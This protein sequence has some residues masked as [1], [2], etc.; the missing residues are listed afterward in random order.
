MFFFVN[1]AILN[2]SSVACYAFAAVFRRG[3]KCI[4]KSLVSRPI[5]VGQINY[6][7]WWTTAQTRPVTAARIKVG[8]HINYAGARQLPLSHSTLH[9]RLLCFAK[10]FRFAQK[11]LVHQDEPSRSRRAAPARNEK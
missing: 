1:Y 10:S 8:L 3:M 7:T 9:A 4:R 5:K 2:L 11:S 6:E